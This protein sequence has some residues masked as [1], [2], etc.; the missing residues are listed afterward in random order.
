LAI[1]RPDLAIS[2]LS[3]GFHYPVDSYLE[4]F[5]N[6]VTD[7]GTLILDLR[8][9][10]ALEQLRKISPLGGIADLDGPPKVLRILLRKGGAA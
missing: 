8:E 3:C 10:N 9:S 2:F 4:F 5:R 7:N 1:A 6:T